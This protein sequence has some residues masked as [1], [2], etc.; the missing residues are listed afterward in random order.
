M[1][2]QLRG[3]CLCLGVKAVLACLVDL[4]CQGVLTYQDSLSLAV[5]VQQA[6]RQVLLVLKNLVALGFGE[7]TME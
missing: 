2:K 6:C 7:A 4:P 5:L 1:C 3:G